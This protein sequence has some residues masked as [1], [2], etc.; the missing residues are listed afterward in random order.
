MAA[1]FTEGRLETHVGHPQKE[2]PGTKDAYVSYEV[3]TKVLGFDLQLRNP[4]KRI[5][6]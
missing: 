1:E 5:V 6:G 3:T 4:S 2:L